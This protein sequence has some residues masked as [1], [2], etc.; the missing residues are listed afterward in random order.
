MTDLD[1]VQTEEGRVYRPGLFAAFPTRRRTVRVTEPD[2]TERVV[3]EPVPARVVTEHTA[4]PRAARALYERGRRDERA[5]RRGSPLLGFV[6]L[7]IAVVGGAMVYLAAREGSFTNGGKVVDHALSEAS[8]PARAAAHNAG[9]ALEN[10]GRSL[11]Q[12]SDG[13][14]S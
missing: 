1:R 4:D 3:T 10:A 12:S 7:L 13:S 9:D 14:G 11:K 2:G 6:M 8:Q 5:R